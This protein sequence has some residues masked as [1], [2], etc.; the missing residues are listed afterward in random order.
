MRWSAPYPGNVSA[1]NP[2]EQRVAALLGRLLA[3]L[4][5]H[6]DFQD[7]FHARRFLTEPCPTI[8]VLFTRGGQLRFHSFDSTPLAMHPYLRAVRRQFW[9]EL[10]PNDKLYG[11]RLMVPIPEPTAHQTALG[12]MWLDIAY[13]EVRE[14]G[15]ETHG[16]TSTDRAGG[17]RM[18]VPRDRGSGGS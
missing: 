2:K 12:R 18:D 1:Q 4:Y 16:S 7:R 17:D 8:D 6:P 9:S 3:P 13:P 14:S 10:D 11:Q 5:A 15:K